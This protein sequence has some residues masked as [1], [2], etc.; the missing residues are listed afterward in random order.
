MWADDPEKNASWLG[1]WSHLIHCDQCHALIGTLVCSNCGRDYTQQSTSMTFNIDGKDLRVP[2]LIFQGALSWTTHSLLALMKREWDRPLAEA[3]EWEQ[4]GRPSQRMLIVVLFWTLFEHHMDRLLDAGLAT[5]PPAIRAD[6][7]RRYSSIG[8]RMDQLYKLTFNATM[9]GDLAALGYSDVFEHLV[10][11]QERRNEF[12]HGNSEAI[13]DNLV[14]EVVE[15]LPNVQ[16]A[17]LALY[18]KR[19]TGN[20]RAAPVWIDAQHKKITKS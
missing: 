1:P 13:N 6:L 12:V 18:N 15:R 3:S 2:P 17:W 4:D 8:S 7:L 14:R 5:T 10:Q 11:V 9:K 19:C 20:P 16:A